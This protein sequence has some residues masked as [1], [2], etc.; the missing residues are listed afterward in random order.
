[1]TDLASG[2][3]KVYT[4]FLFIGAGGGSLPL[5]E[6]PM[7]LKEKFGWFSV[8]GQW[9]KCTNPEVIAKHGAKVYGKA[10]VGRHQCQYRI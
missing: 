7:F 2:Q 10:S 6:K 1:V 3:K 4:K 9:L 8:S 5:L